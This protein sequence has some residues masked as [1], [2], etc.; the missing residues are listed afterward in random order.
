M[1]TGSIKGGGK[2]SPRQGVYKE[3]Q[4]LN[5]VSLERNNERGEDSEVCPFQQAQETAR[6][7]WGSE[8][9]RNH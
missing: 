1:T 5:S 6:Q 9:E 3:G 8:V 2:K 7:L 4:G